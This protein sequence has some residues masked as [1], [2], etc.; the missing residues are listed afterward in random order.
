M[1]G[2]NNVYASRPEE[3][4]D[5]VGGL[6]STGPEPPANG[7]YYETTNASGTVVDRRRY[8]GGKKHSLPIGR[9][10]RK[11]AYYWTDPTDGS[12]Y[13]IGTDG[14]KTLVSKGNKSNNSRRT[15]V[16]NV[17]NSAR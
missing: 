3:D 13:L 1:P 15:R 9:T 10:Q 5:A 6:I 11:R 4:G 16:T 2:T 17:S 12:K 14:S 8:F 7:T